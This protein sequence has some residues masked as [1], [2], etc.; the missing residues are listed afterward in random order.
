[1]SYNVYHQRLF[2]SNTD[3]AS[4]L[5][6]SLSNEEYLDAVSAPRQDPGNRRRKKPLTRKQR[7]QIER[8]EEATEAQ[9]AATEDAAEQ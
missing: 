4:K 9:E 1:M 7:T 6:S 2:V 3:E 8:G 5:T